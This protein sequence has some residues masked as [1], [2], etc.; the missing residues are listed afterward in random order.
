MFGS[1]LCIPWLLLTFLF[2]PLLIPFFSL[3]VC[4]FSDP[5]SAVLVALQHDF[6]R[7]PN[8][9][10]FEQRSGTFSHLIYPKK[11]NSF[12]LT[13]IRSDIAP[14]KSSAL[15]YNMLGGT[16]IYL[17]HFCK[18]VLKYYCGHIHFIDYQNCIKLWHFSHINIWLQ[19]WTC[20]C[21]STLLF[22]T[23]FLSIVPRR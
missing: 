2:P 8:D 4:W 11:F 18:R 14:T 13:W 3:V 19:D 9:Q 17:V 21:S 20:P 22:N 16:K 15:T 5:C 10:H 12:L 1:F 6:S 23:L 7:C